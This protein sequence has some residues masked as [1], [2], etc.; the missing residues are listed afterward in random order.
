MQRGF[1][2]VTTRILDWDPFYPRF[3]LGDFDTARFFFHFIFP[4]K[5]YFPYGSPMC[6]LKKPLTRWWFQI[7]FIFTPTWGND[8]IWLIFFRWVETTN[9]LK[10]CHWPSRYFLLGK[11]S[12]LTRPNRWCDLIAATWR[13][14]S[15]KKLLHG[16]FLT[17]E[18]LVLGV[19][20]GIRN[21]EDRVGKDNFLTNH[22]F[23]WLHVSFHTGGVLLLSVFASCF[24]SLESL[25]LVWPILIRAAKRCSTA[26]KSGSLEYRNIGCQF[27]GQGR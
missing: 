6:N 20:V 1:I 14:C 5:L 22:P 11:R 21:K 24:S 25:W 3:S 16:H 17:M 7:F 12:L 23:F 19:F 13:S 26:V 27:K 15:L 4:T 18:Q 8:P 10:F 9:E 2:T